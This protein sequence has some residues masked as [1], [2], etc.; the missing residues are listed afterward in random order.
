MWLLVC[1]LLM[2][3]NLLI[4]ILLLRCWSL[5]FS[6]LLL[7]FLLLLLHLAM[8]FLKPG[9]LPHQHR[10]SDQQY[11]THGFP[12][13]AAHSTAHAAAHD[14]S[15]E[16][17]IEAVP[18]LGATRVVGLFLQFFRKKF[19]KIAHAFPKRESS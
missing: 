6:D 16:P 11:G 12:S 4:Y 18:V 14:E 10:S 7:Q 8:L 19:V 17:L 13:H 1:G 3:C 15:I 5:K 9:V 2:F